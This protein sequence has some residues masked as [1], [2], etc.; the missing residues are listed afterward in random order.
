MR[1][2]LA[3]IF[4][5][6]VGTLLPLFAAI[7][8]PQPELYFLSFAPF[9][10]TN[11]YTISAASYNWH[12]GYMSVATKIAML[13]VVVLWYAIQKATKTNKFVGKIYLFIVA[14][15]I[16]LFSSKRTLGI[17][18]LLIMMII[19][20]L[21]SKTG[22]IKKIVFYGG[23]SVFYF[24]LYQ[25]IVKKTV[26]GGVSTITE[27]YI[28]YF[29]RILDFRYV[30]YSILHPD[31][32]RILDYPCQSFLFDILPFIKRSVWADKPYPFGVYYTAAWNNQAVSTVSYR[33]TVSWFA[34]AF[35]NLSWMGIPIGVWLYKRM[36]DL[37]ERFQNPI[38]SVFSIY[39]AVYFMV[40]HVQS[41]F[42]NVGILAFLY[43]FI[44]RRYRRKQQIYNT[45]VVSQYDSVKCERDY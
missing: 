29:S 41:N 39:V 33:Y 23:L 17:L 34:E 5:T 18:L 43:F 45:T 32:V 10:R 11:V 7:L 6:F 28:I 14:A 30:T 4:I 13:S 15:V 35:A 1:I 16:L 3:V 22:A 26:G 20:I 37:F 2:P 31:N 44:E 24:V 27:M 40:T 19:E 38:V 12:S 9:S 25:S 8:S 36:L 42:S 21:N